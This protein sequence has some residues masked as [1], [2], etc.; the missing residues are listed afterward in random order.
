[1]LFRGITDELFVRRW[2]RLAWL[3]GWLACA[4]LGAVAAE[5]VVAFT[6]GPRDTLIGL[7]ERVFVSPQAWREVAKINRLR[8]PDVLRPGQ[9][10]QIPVRLLR[11]SLADARIVSVS[12]DVR[13]DGQAAQAQATLRE[14]QSIE[15]GAEGSAV[16]EL[17]D[18]SRVKVA[19]SSLAEVVQ[20]RRLGAAADGAA[21][22][23]TGL[24]SG[25]LRLLRG[26][27][28][29]FATKVLRAKPLEVTTPTAVIG[30]RGTQYRVGFD[31]AANRS[32]RAEVIEGRVR[33]DIDASTPGADVP[34][35]FGAAAD[36]TR[37]P[38]SV[39]RLPPPPDLSP[40][41]LLFERP[42]VRFALASEVQPLRLQVSADPAFDR[43]VRELRIEPGTEVRVAGL[44]DGQWHV[45]AR[46]IDPQG[47]E[48]F[49]AVQSFVLK[50]RPEPP[51]PTQPRSRA[52]QAVGEV[53]FGWAQNVEARS[54]RL[55]VASDPTFKNIVADLPDVTGSSARVDLPTPGAY[56]WRLASVRAAGDQGPFGDALSFELRPLPELALGGLGDDGKS[57]RFSWAGR[58][59][60]RQLVELA[61]DAQFT[62]II[63]QADLNALEWVV[64]KPEQA[65]DYFFRYRS[66]EPDGFTSPYSATLKTTVQP[67]PDTLWKQFLLILPVLLPF[68]FTL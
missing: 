39:V 66:V 14:G 45:R 48:G 18:A 52:K 12:G 37:A 43:V 22:A 62:S 40:I 19:P 60:D 8:D 41:P 38:P 29:V 20:S 54:Q 56:F 11:W 15:T 25:A 35:G 34:G 9:V 13:V 49:D 55:Q 65:G 23:S 5:P 63:A 28:E 67:A 32:S 31:E 1:M 27:V 16:L 57:L 46:R 21:G 6:V 2:L 3:G 26:S 61:R 30:V 50:A 59:Q 42:I 51:A 4:G 47:I 17:A 68:L 7:S 36:A 24:F 33:L 53:A 58:P 64:P 10:L 44:D